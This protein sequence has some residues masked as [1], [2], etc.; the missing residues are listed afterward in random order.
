M[1]DLQSD[2]LLHNSSNARLERCPSCQAKDLKHLRIEDT[3]EHSILRKN[4]T[5]TLEYRR[6]PMR[7]LQ[8]QLVTTESM[9]WLS[10][11]FI[12]KVKECIDKM[13]SFFTYS[14]NVV[15]NSINLTVTAMIMCSP[16]YTLVRKSRICGPAPIIVTSWFV[17][18]FVHTI[19]NHIRPDQTIHPCLQCILMESLRLLERWW[20]EEYDSLL[21]KNSNFGSQVL[22]L[23][24]SWQYQDILLPN[25][26]YTNHTHHQTYP[27]TW[28]CPNTS[29]MGQES[30][31]ENSVL[32]GLQEPALLL[33]LATD[34][35]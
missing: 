14:Y 34:S 2:F 12:H 3:L 20:E 31:L 9:T 33:L 1:S 28:A 27:S 30:L 29:T 24:Q 25:W 26:L 15:D 23:L 35:N 32:Q 17:I 18:D 5:K 22:I 21:H 10:D 6:I 11:E 13:T 7:E 4:R 16:L 8:L 19:Y